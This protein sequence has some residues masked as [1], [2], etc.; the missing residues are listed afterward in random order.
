[1]TIS[2]I[3]SKD[4]LVL[5]FR[6]LEGKP[7]KEFGRFRL[8][9]DDEGCIYGVDI[10]PFVEE[11]EEFKK[12]RNAARLGG[13]WKGIKITDEDIKQI[14]EGLLKKLGEKW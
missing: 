1:M 12:I 4:E 13:L 9:W 11:L 2:Y 8:W 3:P 14:R 7:S 10:M 5:K 6:A